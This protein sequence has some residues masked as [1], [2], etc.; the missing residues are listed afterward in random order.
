MTIASEVLA[1]PEPAAGETDRESLRDEIFRESPL[2]I[3]ERVLLGTVWSLMPKRIGNLLP[4]ARLW[5][6]ELLDPKPGLPAFGAPVGPGEFAGMAHE[7]SPLTLLA[8]YARGLYPKAHFGPLKWMSPEERC[9]LFFDE[10][11][12]PKRL[13]RLMRQGKYSVTFDRAFEHVIKACAGKREGRW[14]VTWITPRIMRERKH[15]LAV[16]RQSFNFVHELSHIG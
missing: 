3:C 10:Y 5:L 16:L 8:A 1:R 11:H 14:H 9:V 7:L 4:L 13:R 6:A 15:R 12:L 2:Q